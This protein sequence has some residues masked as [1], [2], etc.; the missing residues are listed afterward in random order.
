MGIGP[1]PGRS[2]MVNG[3]FDE[4]IAREMRKVSITY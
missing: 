4:D 1:P 2:A 3:S